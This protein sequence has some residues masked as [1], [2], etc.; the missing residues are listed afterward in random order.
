MR[1]TYKN[2]FTQD[3]VEKRMWSIS[4]EP[5]FGIGQ[6]AILLETDEGNVLWDCIAY[7]DDETI[8]TIKGKGGLKAIVISHPHY[9]TT[10]LE[11]AKAFD[12]PVYISLEDETWLSQ[13]DTEGGRKFINGATEEIIPGVIAAKPGGHFPGSLVLLW[14][15]MLMIADTLLTVPVSR[16]ITYE[17]RID[18][19]N[20]Q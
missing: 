1:G 16:L 9:Y 10:H 18:S 8:E 6:R 19:A 4:T 14:N 15:K 3:E 5:K 2:T 7:I 20:F 17:G 12:C 11:W 13:R